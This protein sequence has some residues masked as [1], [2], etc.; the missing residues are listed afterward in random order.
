MIFSISPSA[1]IE[2]CKNVFFCDVEKWCREEGFVDLIIPQIYYGFENE[3][4]PFEEIVNEWL[5]VEKDENVKL[6]F[7]LAVY[8]CGATDE[9]A[10][11]GKNEWKENNDIILN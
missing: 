11:S 7:G 2:K 6:Y 8:K 10:G 4:M 1:D 3:T 9:N 5:S